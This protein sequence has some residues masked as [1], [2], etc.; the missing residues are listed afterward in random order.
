VCSGRSWRIRDLLH[1]LLSLSSASIDV[2]ID[3]ARFRRNDVP[4]VQGDGSRIRS[5]LDW[6]PTIR[7]EQ[8]LRDTLDWWREE[9]PCP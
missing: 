8:T 7:V 2:E 9:T 5:E 6:T 3:A 1:E 4:I